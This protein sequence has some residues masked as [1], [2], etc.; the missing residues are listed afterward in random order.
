MGV[1]RRAA[2]NLP[3]LALDARSVSKSDDGGVGDVLDHV[4]WVLAASVVDVL[5]ALDEVGEGGV[6]HVAGR[7]F[8]VRVG[9]DDL[10]GLFDEAFPFVAE[11]ERGSFRRHINGC[12]HRGS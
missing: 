3:P 7:G 10:L 2:S 1:R 5:L 12:M 8:I 6:N 11:S 4:R 9:R